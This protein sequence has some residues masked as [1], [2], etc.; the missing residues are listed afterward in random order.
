MKSYLKASFTHSRRLQRKKEETMS[1]EHR[2]N[3]RLTY[4]AKK[5]TEDNVEG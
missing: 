3:M 2:R 4:I 5:K 1:E